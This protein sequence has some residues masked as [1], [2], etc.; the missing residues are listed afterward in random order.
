MRRK[1]RLVITVT[2]DKPVSERTARLYVDENMRYF[3][4]GVTKVAP[5]QN[6]E[7]VLAKEIA[8]R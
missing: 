5:A 8:K 6:F 2:F 7:R 1:Q 4:E 3:G